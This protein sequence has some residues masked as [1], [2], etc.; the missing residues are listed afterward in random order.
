[1]HF[2]VPGPVI[3]HPNWRYNHGATLVN[4]TSAPID[5]LYLTLQI[6]PLGHWTGALRTCAFD[7][8]DRTVG[9]VALTKPD[10]TVQLRWG[11]L[12]ILP[13]QGV[14]CAASTDYTKVFSYPLW[15]L[16]PLWRM[17]RFDS[18]CIYAAQH[19]R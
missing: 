14:A 17:S 11:P 16:S 10:G 12:R 13:G 6:P 18:C 9:F 1:V 3:L 7:S 5:D 15:F 8:T 2:S 4:P 19:D